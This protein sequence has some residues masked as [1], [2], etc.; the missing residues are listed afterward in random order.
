MAIVYLRV[1]REVGLRAGLFA[2][3]S[4][5]TR[6]TAYAAANPATS[7]DSPDVP[8]TA[9]KDSILAAEKELAGLIGAST[10]PLWR[11]GLKS[12]SSSIA[13][14]GDIP[15]VDASAKEFI[16]NP[17]GFFDASNGT[18]LTEAPKRVV[19]RRASNPGSFFVG[20]H[21]L[22]AVEG[23]KLLHTRNNA[24][25]R[26][27]VWDYTTQ[28]S[29]YDTRGTSASPLPQEFEAILVA[30]A[31]S[32]LPT[33]DWVFDGA[34]WYRSLAQEKLMEISQGRLTL[35]TLPKMPNERARPNPR[36]D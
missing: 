35:M 33:E 18:P 19:L 30:R 13:H 9:L 24:V 27:C 2:G 31:L 6:E 34:E 32:L 7:M 36:T 1:I 17:D 26:G 21:Y 15:T 11:S 3:G 20:E 4:S 29:L 12:A 28:A 14:L 16:G 22:F 23:T 8:A 10:N 25:M 5:S